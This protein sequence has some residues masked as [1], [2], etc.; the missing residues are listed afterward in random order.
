MT[1]AIAYYRVSTQEQGRSGL[2]IEAQRQTVRAFASKHGMTLLFEF[3]EVETG[4]G[5]DALEQRPKL[6]MAFREAR[7]Q[8]CAVLV[9][10]LDR[11][12]RDVAFISG[13]MAQKVRFYAADL[14]LTVDPFM[15]H[16]YAALAQ[17]ERD[18]ISQRTKDALRAK[19]AQGVRLGNPNPA[20]SAKRAHEARTAAADRFAANVRPVIESIRKAGA[21]SYEAIAIEM[22]ARNVKTARGGSW[23]ATTVRNAM[24]RA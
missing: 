4:K 21:N 12:S 11:L 8:K 15:L 23:H 16:V 22:N 10:K 17:K 9:A 20:A 14:G 2:G 13:L 5:S 6:A 18:L 3:E 7:R 1:S 24:K 19:K